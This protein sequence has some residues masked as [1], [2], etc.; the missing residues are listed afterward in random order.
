M[1]DCNYDLDIEC[2]LKNSATINQLKAKDQQLQ[3][4]VNNLNDTINKNVP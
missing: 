3:N 2:N 4:Q 1:V